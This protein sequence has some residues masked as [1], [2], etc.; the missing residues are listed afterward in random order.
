MSEV[1]VKFELSDQDRGLL[2]EILQEL[3]N[4]R[5]NCERCVKQMGDAVQNCMNAHPVDAVPPATVEDVALIDK[6]APKRTRKK[7]TNEETKPAP[8]EPPKDEPKPEPVKEYTE[9]DVHDKVVALIQAGKRNEA[10]SIVKE[11]ASGV[12]EIPADKRAEV[13]KRLEAVA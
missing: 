2:T 10:R 1:T 7:V 4:A 12:S 5:P 8:A 11:Y 3:K 9:K 13:M 6:E